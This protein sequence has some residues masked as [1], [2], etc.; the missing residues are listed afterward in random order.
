MT[1]GLVA[2]ATWIAVRWSRGSEP[3]AATR[4]VFCCGVAHALFVLFVFGPP[5]AW[6]YEYNL[7]LIGCAAL[8]PA[9]GRGRWLGW[10]GV[11]VVL[12]GCYSH[13]V[14]THRMW[15]E[16]GRVP[17]T[18]GLYAP[19]PQADGWARLTAA[20]DGQKVFVFHYLGGAEVLDAR[21]TSPSSW[22]LYW[23]NAPPAEIDRAVQK[24]RRADVVVIPRYLG[25]DQAPTHP[26]NGPV[27]ADELRAFPVVE[28]WPGYRVL[29]QS[30]AGGPD[31]QQ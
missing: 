16:L 8:L 4:G 28:E 9:S 14:G 5:T 17:G 23:W 30:A 26:A 13:A 27:F 11:G 7:L 3:T 31:R 12:L 18:P 6:I 15:R 22:C 29:H 20:A 19:Q 10:G 24:L 21:L 1:V 2:A 25:M